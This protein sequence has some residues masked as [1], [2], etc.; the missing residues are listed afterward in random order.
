MHIERFGHAA[1]KVRDL[2]TSERFYGDVLGLAVTQ[3]FPEDHE[4]IFGVGAESH[5]LVQ[6]LGPD[7]R[8]PDATTIGLHHVAFVVEGGEPGLESAKRT[9]DDR[10]IAYRNVD[11]GEHR[12]V[13]FRDPDGHQVELYHGAHEPRI[14]AS[15]PLAER[16]S[17]ARDFLLC[18][19]RLVD[20]AAYQVAFEHAP[21]DRL[22]SAL[23]AYR[24]ADG[25]F[26]HALEPDLRT[27]ASQPLHTLTGLALSKEAG[28]RCPAVANGCCEYFSRIARA[29][30]A[31]P[32]FLDGALDYPA[33]GHWRAGIGGVPSLDWTLAAAA[34]ARW[35]G[36]SHRWLDQAVRQCRHHLARADIAEAHA[37]VYAIDFASTVLEGRERS[38]AL[39][40]LVNRLPRASWY[41]TATPAPGYGLT[42]L[43]YAPAPSHP[44][45]V[46]FAD[47]LVERHLDDLFASQQPDGGWTIRFQPPS[48]A[49]VHEWRGRSTLEA[50]HTLRAYGRL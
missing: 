5:L 15:M 37:L 22:V 35:H 2:D 18:N 32:A 47:D 42:A 34:L 44:A 45:R 19:A 29:D 39:E 27:P 36:A 6:A 30:G 16:L 11:H 31:L 26:G 14:E 8:I 17:R 21:P 43:H 48:A 4:V 13:Y 28:V 7:A 50:L 49:A 1:L 41:I 3:R 20:R 46:C 12:S 24:N 38:A 33:A 23:D 25:G 40:E 9:L 10:G